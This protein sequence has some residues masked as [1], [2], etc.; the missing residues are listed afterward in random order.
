MIIETP[1]QVNIC[2]KESQ[3]ENAAFIAENGKTTLAQVYAEVRYPK[4][5]NELFSKNLNAFLDERFM[6]K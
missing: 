1:E 5:T 3:E 6:Q 4:T 2:G